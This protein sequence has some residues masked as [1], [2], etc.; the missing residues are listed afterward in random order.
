MSIQR[1]RYEHIQD[2]EKQ[3]R[4]DKF[5]YLN[6]GSDGY[7]GVKNRIP[8]FG[9]CTSLWMVVSF[10]EIENKEGKQIGRRG[11]E[12]EFGIGNAEWR[13]AVKHLIVGI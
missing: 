7:W 8:R 4:I 11:W 12:D 5:Y 13:A 3:G 9:D 1:I 6:V 2:R 10:I